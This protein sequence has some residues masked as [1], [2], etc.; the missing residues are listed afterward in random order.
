MRIILQLPVQ[1]ILAR[2][3]GPS[4]M[5][6]FAICFI[7]ISLSYFFA[8][9]GIA[10]A[11]IQ[12]PELNKKDI[13]FVF[14][15]QFILGITVALSLY[16][17]RIPIANLFHE[18]D[19][20]QILKI[21]CVVSFLNALTSPSLN[22]LRRQLN[23]KY[24]F[25]CSIA[26]YI[27]AYVAIGIPLALGG[28]G[29]ASLVVALLTQTSL[30]LFLLY[31]KTRHPLGFLLWYSDAKSQLLY[32][33]KV[34]GANLS[35]WSISNI[36]RT[37][38]GWFFDSTTVGFYSVAYN[39]IS[40]PS[41]ALAGTLQ[42]TFFST[43]SRSR[44]EYARGALSSLVGFVPLIIF[45]LYV[46]V[47]TVPETIVY[48]LYGGEWLDAAAFL[49]PLALAIPF[50]FIVAI[51]VPV[52]W[53]SGLIGREMMLNLPFAA[54]WFLA[55][56][57]AARYSAA[58]VAWTTGSLVA[59]RGTVFFLMAARIAGVDHKIVWRSML[60]TAALTSFVSFC[61]WLADSFGRIVSV[62]P[63]V[64]LS[65]DVAAGS[66]VLLGAF[67]LFSNI[68]SPSTAQ[69]ILRAGPRVPLWI[70]RRMIRLLRLDGTAES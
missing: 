11:L 63:L 28:F 1:I 25:Q 50:S 46:G 16:F 31:L 53:A 44:D 42:S 29:I 66:A 23:Y 19:V 61:I 51:S 59:A 52:I 35:N 67:F 47:A 30:N 20:A 64:W 68:V 54:V 58:A 57:L 17:F 62:H 43:L 3:L 37:I 56:F 9:I 14:T 69:L 32:G 4:Q 7:V 41:N 8:D 27:L 49:R 36:D 18:H 5:G 40:T 65:T 2:L 21:L 10:Y 70:Q 45:P 38:V 39:F 15:W 12:K 26:T 60:T 55:S 22:L 48:A 13:R 6:L 33:I 24:I 34:F